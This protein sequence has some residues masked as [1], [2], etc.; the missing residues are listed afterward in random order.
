MPHTQRGVPMMQPMTH[1]T[2]VAGIPQM[3]MAGQ[4]IPM[5]MHPGVPGTVHGGPSYA[6]YLK[7]GSVSD[8]LFG[9]VDRDRDGQISKQEFKTALKGGILSGPAG[10][11]YDLMRQRR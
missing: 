7:A 9:M 3:Q 6:S 4:A 8:D 11:S 5:P 1:T 2:T 10:Q